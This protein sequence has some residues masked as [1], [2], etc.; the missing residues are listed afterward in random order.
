V[1]QKFLNKISPENLELLIENLNHNTPKLMIDLY[2][3]YFCQKLIQSC[4]A[5]Q[6][7]SILNYVNNFF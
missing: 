5:E 4:S 2:G 7:I 1:L 6:R 3:N